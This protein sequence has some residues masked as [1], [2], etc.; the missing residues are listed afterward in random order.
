MVE[1]SIASAFI[2]EDD[3]DWDVR[4]LSQ[5]PGLAKGVRTLSNIPLSK[6]QHSPYGDDWDIIWPGHCGELPPK[7]DFRTYIISDD[8]TVAPQSH[9]PWLMGVK[10]LPEGSR[11]IHRVG[12][13][14]CAFGY[15]VSLRGAQKILYWLGIKGGDSLAIDNGL[16]YMCRNREMGINCWS[17]EPQLFNHHR[18]AGS[19]SKDSDI[20]QKDP[21]IIR[22]KAFTDV[23]V[24]SARLN[25][26]QMIMGSE[27]YVKQW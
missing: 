16:G 11:V 26:A 7:D 10:H 19:I 22:E 24:W 18:P 27:D 8:P 6:H 2:M 15:A 1:E 21:A 4:L 23:I 13:P 14:I 5:M 17:V 12:G 3:A 20:N 25:L 9:Q